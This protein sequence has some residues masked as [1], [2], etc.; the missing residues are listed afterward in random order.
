M[1]TATLTAGPAGPSFEPMA[2]R[3]ASH[4]ASTLLDISCAELDRQVREAR[5]ELE[6]LALDES[7]AAMGEAARLEM[8][9]RGYGA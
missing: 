9:E 6:R 4:H 5:A 2:E 1:T 8:L 7:F 3:L